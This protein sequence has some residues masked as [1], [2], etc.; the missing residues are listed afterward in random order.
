MLQSLLSDADRFVVVDVETTG[1]YN[2]D[3]IV[4]V[5]AV[6]VDASGRIVDEWDTLVDPQRDIGPTHIHGLTA[7]MVSVAPTFEQVAAALA[8]RL[9]GAVLVAHNLAF[10]ARMLTNEFDRLGARLVPGHGVCTLQLG[11]GKLED[12]CR[13]CG[14]ELTHAHRALGDA[15][16]AAQLLGQLVDGQVQA[17]TS[18]RVFDV[19]AP[20]SARTVQREMV[21][22]REIPM[23]YL[24]RLASHVHH[25]GEH[26]ATL[27]YLDM[28]DWALADLVIT[29]QED[30]ELHALAADL[31]MSSDDVVRAHLRYVD[32]L[33][34]A[35]LRDEVVTDEEYELLHRVAAALGVDPA[36]IDTNTAA[37]RP[38]S[39][40]VALQA[41]MRVC[42]TG[43]ATYP[44]GS[45]L[46]RKKL[47]DIAA[48]LGLEPT[49]SVTKKN[50]DLLV[51]SDTSSQSGKAGKARSYGIPLV[52]V[53]DFLKAK[54]DSTVPAVTTGRG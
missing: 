34:A 8:N 17:C 31:G 52:D 6:T 1:L 18:A 19:S 53:R 36:V 51:A 23:P 28:L 43:T 42:F 16:A 39:V 12:I 40:G 44:D 13:S 7:S 35:A 32:E 25:Y 46:P 48:G 9:Y 50:C 27:A 26:G 20:Y 21:G 24:A 47:N 3:R 54:P 4:E 41:G 14:V 5:A 45:E 10:D 29:K 38:N 30:A 33:V 22:A 2:S 49:S 11:G 15:R 37:W